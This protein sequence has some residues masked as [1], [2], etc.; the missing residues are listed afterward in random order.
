M[1]AS[2]EP[3][4]RSAP[5]AQ[6]SSELLAA[7]TLC[8]VIALLLLRLSGAAQSSLFLDEAASLFLAHSSGPTLTEE[9]A[10]DLSPPLFTLLIRQWVELFGDS[11]LAA[12]SLSALASALAGGLCFVLVS[13][14]FGSL[15]G[16]LMTALFACSTVQQNAGQEARGFALSI[17]WVALAWFAL[18]RLRTARQPGADSRG[19]LRSLIATLGFWDLVLVLANSLILYTHY[20][21]ALVLPAQLVAVIFGIRQPRALLMR[22]LLLDGAALFLA[23]PVFLRLRSE[24]FVAMGRWY[25]VPDL[26]AL[27]RLLVAYAGGRVLA[28]LVIAATVLAT[29]LVARARFTTPHQEHQEDSR[30]PMAVALSWIWLPVALAFALSYVSPLFLPKYLRFPA[31]GAD[32]LLVSAT[33]VLFTQP[34]TAK[35]HRAP[36]TERTA[37]SWTGAA[38]AVMLL[39]LLVRLG[40][41]ERVSV[42]EQE[43]RQTAAIAQTLANDSTVFVVQASYQCKPFAYYF[44]RIAF[45]QPEKFHRLLYDSRV[46]CIDQLSNPDAFDALAPTRVVLVQSH[47][48]LVDPT[49]VTESALGSRYTRVRQQQLRGVSLTVFEGPHTGT[50]RR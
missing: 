1:K 50:T 6:R 25:D 43:W 15:Y 41:F 22:L 8:V 7:G 17:L 46:I 36:G 26:A 48:Q 20:A 34:Q 13:R 45:R 21:T 9:L 49:A 3:T 32:L 2:S 37:R 12:R 11:E 28:L 29:G 38:I 5:G 33:F 24:M 14:W 16:A 42:R 30:W 18:D 44:S 47:A 10:R 35:L 19:Y 23:S 39:L 27:W 40:S 31:P 4:S